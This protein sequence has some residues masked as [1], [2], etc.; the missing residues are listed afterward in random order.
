MLNAA[1][2]PSS[3][4]IIQINDIASLLYLYEIPTMPNT[5]EAKL[6]AEK[7]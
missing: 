1:I 2:I 5:S 7:L 4:I 3:A 6:L